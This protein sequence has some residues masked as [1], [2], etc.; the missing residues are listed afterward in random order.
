ME[1]KTSL[2]LRY[3][4]QIRAEFDRLR[5]EYEP[6]E[7]QLVHLATNAEAE[8]VIGCP[9][10]SQ[11]RPQSQLVAMQGAG[12]REA[13][14]RCDPDGNPLF[15][16]DPIVD[17]E[18]RPVMD[19]AGKA[20]DLVM[21]AH[22]RLTFAGDAGCYRALND[23]AVRAGRL[24][25]RMVRQPALAVLREWRFSTP[26]DS[27][28]A[29]VF[30]IAWA[31]RH[32]LLS[33]ERRLWL[34]AENPTTFV[35]YGIDQLRS[36]AASGF[37]LAKRIPASWLKRL[38]EA[39]VSEL[40]NAA[41][42]SFDAADYLITELNPPSEPAPSVGEAHESAQ[43]SDPSPD[44]QI[45]R[46]F[47]IALSFP[48]ER[49]ELVDGVARA[50]GAALGQHRVFYDRFHQAELSRPKLDLLLQSI[51]RDESDLVVVFICGEYD[52]KE[53]CGVEWEAIRDL[54]KQK[55]RPAEDVMF[56]RLDSGPVEGMLSTCGFLDI[57]R[58][59]A[60]EIA[61]AI[62]RRLSNRH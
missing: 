59:S 62:L 46:R 45:K 30:E 57:S 13:R 28:W 40:E 19:S 51:Y 35:Q 58:K 60:R 16:D 39:F 8:G 24:I 18:G 47:A 52:R 6:I 14:Q 49:R 10:L 1:M 50:L 34:P 38:P 42:A 27:W 55:S 15:R 11:R 43:A 41:V 33:T 17:V 61:D 3:L 12:H 5:W 25:M 9:P 21:P 2:A 22:R 23:V 37:E 56:L 4:Q 53:W 31:N 32:P 54:M 36:F 7:V 44:A 26:S 29:A 20:L 48:G